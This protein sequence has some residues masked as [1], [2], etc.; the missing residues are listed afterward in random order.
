MSWII[1]H[2]TAKDIDALRLWLNDAPD[3][4]WIVKTGQSGKSHHWCAVPE[5]D[6]VH[7]QQYALWHIPSGPLNIPSGDHKIPDRLVADPFSGWTQP[8][9]GT[10]TSPWFGANLPG[11]YSLQFRPQGRE[12]ADSIGRSDF[13][14][15]L[16]RFKLIGKP[17]P[18]AAKALWQQ[19][20]RFVAKSATKLPWPDDSSRYFTFVFPDALSQ[21]RAGRHLDVNP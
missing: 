2:A 9:D 15:A 19:L 18:S 14:W 13:Y 4:A 12:Q 5:I 1:M 3:V 16:D 10:Q 11:P 7:P 6:Q 8:L 20:R 21:H 17:A